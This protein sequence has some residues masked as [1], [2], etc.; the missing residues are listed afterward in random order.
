MPITTPI[1]PTPS[2][3]SALLPVPPMGCPS[4]LSLDSIIAQ[5]SGFSQ[6]VRLV[7][8]SP[9]WV[10]QDY[11]PQGTVY[12]DQFGTAEPYP[13]LKILWTIGPTQ[14]PEV[15]VRVTDVQTGESA[16]W[17]NQNGTPA[18]PVLDLP[19]QAATSGWITTPAT[20]AIIHSGCYQI[21]VSWAGGGWHTIFAAG[22]NSRS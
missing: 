17:T 22:G 4:A 9:V 10:P 15:T 19:A 7:G 14:H 13:A 2:P 18:T 21:N 6:P 8:Q 12:L 20:V 11:L 1:V 5:P 3:A 16:W